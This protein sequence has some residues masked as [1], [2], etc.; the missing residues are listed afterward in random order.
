MGNGKRRF[1]IRFGVSHVLVI[2]QIAIS[3]LLV[4]AAGLFVRTLE[5]LHSVDIGFN[6]DKL[7]VFSLDAAQAGYKD[8]ALANLYDQL[9]SRFAA[10]PSVKSATLTERRWCQIRPAQRA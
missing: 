2:L 4:T 6:S 9:Q 5:N 1:G 7:L 3:L 10:I 8:A